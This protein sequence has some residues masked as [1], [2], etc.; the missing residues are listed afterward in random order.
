MIM[1]NELAILLT[2]AASIGVF[3][4]LTGP[5][6]YVPFIALARALD[7]RLPKTL[8]VT[9]G[10]GIGHV[11]SSVLL[12]MIGVACGLAVSRLEGIEAWRGNFAAWALAAFGFAYLVWG[13][14]YAIKNKPHEHPH[15]HGPDGS[16][17]H[18]HAHRDEHAHP[19]LDKGAPRVTPWVLFIVFVFGP[20]E[21]LIPI[22]M[23][24]AAKTSLLGMLLV[25]AVFMAATVGTMLAVVGT[26]TFGLQLTFLGRMER[27]THTMAGG[28][29]LLSALA[30]A[31]LGL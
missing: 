18:V 11:L 26:M 14:R 29:I 4:T 5:D 31:F 6:H 21:P 27:H 15:L 8:L 16:H 10:C 22:L 24:P 1:T 19:H 9:L 20:C 17:V 23:Y 28:A 30:I 7:W 13:I 2:A 3:H 25:V 12:G